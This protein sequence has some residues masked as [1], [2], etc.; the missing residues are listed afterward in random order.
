MKLNLKRTLIAA[1][2]VAFVCALAFFGL[3]PWGAML[4]MLVVTWVIA[5]YASSVG[6]RSC[7]ERSRRNS[8]S[9]SSRT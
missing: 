1:A 5:E 2:Y 3:A 8:C 7:S 4:G 6:R 9:T